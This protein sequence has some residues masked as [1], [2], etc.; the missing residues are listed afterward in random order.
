MTALG[1]ST[2][3]ERLQKR[4]S[5]VTALTFA[6]QMLAAAAFAHANRVIHCDLKPEN[7]LIFPDN[8]LRLMDFGIARV[9]HK[10]MKGS[11][12]GTLG[13]VAPEQAMGKPSFRS[14]VF[15]LGLVIYRLFAGQLPEWPFS[16]PPPGYVRLKDRVHSDVIAWLKKSINVEARQRHRDAAAMLDAFNRIK[17]PLKT[18]RRY[19]GQRRGPKTARSWKEVRRREFMRTV[20]RQLEAIH[21]CAACD[22]P[23]S[24][25]MHAC[26]WCGKARKKHIGDATRFSVECPR[27]RRGLKSD[28]TYC[29]WCFGPGFAPTLQRKLSDKRYVARCDNPKCGRKELMAFM[30]YCPWCRRRVAEKWKIEGSSA[31]CRSC[32]HGL[33]P[34]FWTYCPWCGRGLKGHVSPNKPNAQ[35]RMSSRD[36]PHDARMF[37]DACLTAP[38]QILFPAGEIWIFSKRSPMKDAANEDSAG[39]VFVN[40]TA[41]VF[42]VADGCGGMAGGERASRLALESLASAVQSSSG[43]PDALRS[44]IL[45]GIEAGNRQVQSLK[46]GAATTLAAVEFHNDSVRSYHIGDSTVLLVG[47]RGKIKLHT[48]SHSPVA[49]G[50]EAGLIHEDEAIDHED[51]HLV[52]NVVGTDDTHIEIGPDALWHREILSCLPAMGCSTTCDSTKLS[53][54]YGKGRCARPPVSLLID[55]HKECRRH[56]R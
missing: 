5:P 2:L 24:E 18:K 13:Y 14:D 49:Y 51:L 46:T 35:N 37:F 28:W 25:V 44:A 17:T 43:G 20:G 39:V 1:T 19:N 33:L 15:S 45:D 31:S 42:M 10:T 6:R 29:P 22:G 12:A 11:G 41:A 47:S 38:E 36:H 56:L 53:R 9:A 26:P 16:W 3:E 34:A 40:Q 54:S 27:C 32:G 21:T 8:R 7:M 23:V 50:V 48:R 52:S 55:P 30:R 4:L